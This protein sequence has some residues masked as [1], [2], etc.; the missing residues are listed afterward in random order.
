MFT[1]FS[2]ENTPA[3]QVWD[4]SYAIATTSSIRN[5]SLTDDCAPIQYF[6][7]GAGFT[8]INLYLPSA[9]IEGKQIKII[10]QKF[11]SGNQKIQIYSSDTSANGTGAAIY[12]LGVGQTLDLIY[13]KNFISFGDSNGYYASGWIN[14]NYSPALAANAYAICLGNNSLASGSSSAVVAGDN[15]NATAQYAFVGGGYTNTASGTYAFVGGG[16][17]ANATQTSSAV[18]GGSSNTAGGSYAGVF[19]GT[20]NQSNASY[21]VIAGGGQNSINSGIY[22][23]IG[24]G[25]SNSATGANSGTIGGNNHTTSSNNSGIFVGSYG[26]TRSIQGYTVFPASINPIAASTG[27]SQSALLVLGVQTTDATATVLR[28]N[29]SAATTNNQ[30]ILPSN[31]AYYFRGECIAGITGAGDTKGWYIEGVIKRGAG[32][33]TTA[34]VGTPSV[35]SLYAD[36]G[37]A[38]WAVAVTADTTN[39][40]LKITVTGQASTTIRWVCQIRTTEMTY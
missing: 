39:G 2:S 30:I 6:K 4:C 36:A 9:A 1:G 24:G 20:N 8:A 27:V 40:G 21:G 14:L 22:T 7:T 33:G 15:S 3:I 25:S 10:N 37:A 31:S 17:S 11:S 12:I 16:Q 28:S 29:T 19:C 32:V 18:I 26:N 23:F 13:S 5:F 35:T 34:L 38:T